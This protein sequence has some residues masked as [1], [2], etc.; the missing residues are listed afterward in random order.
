L[1]LKNKHNIL[2]F[3]VFLNFAPLL[4]PAQ[5]K[6]PDIRFD[7][8]G[9]TIALQ[10]DPSFAVD[11]NTPLSDLSVKTFNKRISSSDYQGV[12]KA[13]LSYKT[14]LKLDDW[15]Y[16]QLIRK[17]AQQI[18]PKAVNYPRYTLYKWFLLTRSGYDA[19]IRIA[20]DS[21]LFY[22]QSDE[23]IYN[24]PYCM[25]DGKQYVCLNYHDYGGFI[26]FDKEKFAEV[27]MAVPGA[28]TAF[29]YKVRRLPHFRPGD[30]LEKDIRFSYNQT[31]YSYKV[32][33]NPDIKP[34]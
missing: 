11:F 13:L 14:E 8:Y 6:V 4:L 18:S 34:I 30:Y 24:I 7:F 1:P 16:Y 15:L 3:L 21:I 25:K 32:K 2:F 12:I 17:T 9:D 27:V 23:N 33:I 28:H 29:S 19:L 10:P 22:V 26:D 31:D 20:G 5:N